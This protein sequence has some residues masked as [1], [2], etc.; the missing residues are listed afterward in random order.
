MKINI[1]KL[2]ELSGFSPA[3]VSNA[4]SG[5]R[6][7]S[8]ETSEKII[9]IARDTGYLSAGREREFMK[10]IRV[11]TYRD[12]GAVFADS[13]FFSELLES[14]ENES[15]KEGYEIN[16]INL[17]R[18]QADYASRLREILSDITSGILLVGTE[19][20]EE[21]ARPFAQSE[22]PL[23]LLDAW[24]DRL[25]FDAV[26][27]NNEESVI[28]AVR[29]LIDKG[30]TKIGYLRGTV[31]ISNFKCRERG[32]RK[33]LAD[34]GLVPD[35]AFVF[36]VEP[37]IPGANEGV[38]RAIDEGREMPTAFFAD[39]DMIALGAMH[40]FQARGWQIPRDISIVGFDD[41]TFSEVFTPGLTTVR[42][43]KK[44][45]GQIAVRRLLEKL[46]SPLPI[47]ARTQVINSLI[48]RGSVGKPRET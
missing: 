32:W 25:P 11:V 10:K 34:C 44:E 14:V 19:L 20:V 29:H 9:R 46:H 5:K 30:H 26:L 48:L 41:I 33:A 31:R 23:V 22:A 6:G 27:M 12:S 18:R 35:E 3:T 4:L 38:L 37:S 42:V 28:E 21:T 13:P 16:I 24:F 17:Y 43:M 36:D 40:A 1:K 8:P 39:N 47:H 7:V 2:S 45:L 15:R